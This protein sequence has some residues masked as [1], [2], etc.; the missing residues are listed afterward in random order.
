MECLGKRG[1]EDDSHISGLVIPFTDTGKTRKVPGLAGKNMSLI[2]DKFKVPLRYPRDNV[3][4]AV[5]LGQGWANYG[6]WAKSSL[7]HL[8]IIKFY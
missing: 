6:P 3:K 1:I 2:L 8:F 7:Q 4:G 5:G